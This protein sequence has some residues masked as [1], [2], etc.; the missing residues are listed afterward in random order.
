MDSIERLDA[1]VTDNPTYMEI[2]DEAT[3]YMDEDPSVLMLGEEGTHWEP[4]AIVEAT[5]KLKNWAWEAAAHPME[6]SVKK[7]KTVELVTPTKNIVFVP[8]ESI[9]ASITIPAKSVCDSIPTEFVLVK[10]I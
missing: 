7:I 6:D 10:S 9:S 8:I 3:D 5:T 1:F 2:D 4:P